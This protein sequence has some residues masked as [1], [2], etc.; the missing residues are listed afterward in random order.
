MRIACTGFRKKRIAPSPPATRP[1]SSAIS[2]QALERI[3]DSEGSLTSDVDHSKPSSDIGAPSKTN[4]DIDFPKA[5]SDIGI[6]AQSMLELDS[7]SKSEATTYKFD[8][9]I[10]QIPIAETNVKACS[11]TDS[12]NYM[13]VKADVEVIAPVEVAPKVEQARVATK[14]GKLACIASSNALLLNFKARDSSG[15]PH[16]S[17]DIGINNEMSL[18][19]F[20]ILKSIDFRY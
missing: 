7:K 10:Q 8:D 19:T 3:V 13:L 9:N 2:T 17:E 15:N 1:L 20:C 16:Q 12:V 4:S 14:R 11:E 6:N 5:N 18:A